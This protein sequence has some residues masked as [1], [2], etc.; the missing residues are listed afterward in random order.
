MIPPPG[1]KIKE[2]TEA[3]QTSDWFDNPMGWL[4]QEVQANR[5]NPI[6]VTYRMEVDGMYEVDLRLRFNRSNILKTSAVHR[7]RKTALRFAAKEM[8]HKVRCLREEF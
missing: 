3:S 6:D 1:V 8:F 4:E 2:I 7:K 5:L